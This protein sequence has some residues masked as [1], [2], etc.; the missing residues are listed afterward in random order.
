MKAHAGGFILTAL[1]GGLPSVIN[2]SA[3]SLAF[4]LKET[5]WKIQIFTLLLL[6]LVY[7][8]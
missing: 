4:G 1:A 6:C 5:G 8:R 2:I 3:S 7:V